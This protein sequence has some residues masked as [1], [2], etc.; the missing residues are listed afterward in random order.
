MKLFPHFKMVCA[1]V[2]NINGFKL[3]KIKFNKFPLKQ[4]NM[5][6]PNVSMVVHKIAF[7]QIFLSKYFILI[8]QFI[9]FCI[10]VPNMLA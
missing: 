10:I 7:F 5:V 3:L 9:L 2:N 8:P 4:L 6:F 1:S